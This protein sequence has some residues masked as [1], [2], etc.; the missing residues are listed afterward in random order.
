MQIPT[1]V[2]FDYAPI[3]LWEQDFSGVKRFLDD[4]RARGVLIAVHLRWEVLPSAEA[5]FSRVLVSLATPASASEPSA[6]LPKAKPTFA[7][8]LTMPPWAGGSRILA[9]SSAASTDCGPRA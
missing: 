1:E 6:P 8:C 9:A 7:A 3:S 2:L 5:T 4:L